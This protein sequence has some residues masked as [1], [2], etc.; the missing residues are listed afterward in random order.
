MLSGWS[1]DVSAQMLRARKV[2]Y[3]S[4]ITGASYRGLHDS[5]VNFLGNETPQTLVCLIQG[6]VVSIAHAYA[7]ATDEPISWVLHSNGGLMH[8]I[9]G[10]QSQCQG[11]VSPLIDG[12]SKV[13]YFD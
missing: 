7:K 9:M 13:R 12:W 10:V 2:K 8:G 6:H 5:L 1:S 4:L 11:R 3:V